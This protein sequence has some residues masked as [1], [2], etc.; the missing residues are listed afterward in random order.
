MVGDCPIEFLHTAICCCQMDPRSRPSFSATVKHLEAILLG[1]PPRPELHSKEPIG[2]ITNIEYPIE[3][4]SNSTNSSTSTCGST[5]SNPLLTPTSKESSHRHRSNSDNKRRL[6][7]ISGRYKLFHSGTDDLLKHTPAKLMGFFKNVLGVRAKDH[8][9]KITKHSNSTSFLT[10]VSPLPTDKVSFWNNN[11]TDGLPSCSSHDHI[12]LSKSCPG[13]SGQISRHGQE[14]AFTRRHTI[15][16]TC[17]PPEPI[18]SNVAS[19]FSPLNIHRGSEVPST[20]SDITSLSS[21][22]DSMHD[23]ASTAGSSSVYTDSE[24]SSRHSSLRREPSLPEDDEDLTTVTCK[25]LKALHF[26][27]FGSYSV[28]DAET[29]NRQ[30]IERE[31]RKD[32]LDVLKETTSDHLKVKKRMSSPKLLSFFLGNRSKS[33][34]QR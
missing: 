14:S 10:R 20:S 26:D 18:T 2:I 11:Q 12:C 15:S 25:N 7:W 34:D 5:T 3:Y 21:G 30:E 13:T 1:Y 16:P 8:S 6:S 31:I 24:Y 17:L 29:S 19:E 33:K 32:K 4:P 27:R 22:F 23:S 28:I 9:F